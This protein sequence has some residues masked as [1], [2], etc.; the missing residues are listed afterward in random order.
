MSE[1]LQT[2]VHLVLT[3]LGDVLDEK[4][5]LKSFRKFIPFIL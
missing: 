4:P 5:V 1:I 3:L 2:A